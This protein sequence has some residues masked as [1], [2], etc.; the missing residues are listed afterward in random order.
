MIPLLS[1]Y[2]QS[3]EVLF[4]EYFLPSFEKYLSKSFR[5][6]V[7]TGHQD[8]PSSTYYRKGWFETVVK[9]IDFVNSFLQTSNDELLVFADVD[10]VF[11]DNFKDSLLEELGNNDMAF[12]RASFSN[13]CTGFYA[14]KIND[15]N[16]RFFDDLL[17]SYNL[18]KGDQHNINKMLS[19]GNYNSTLLSDKFH[20][21]NKLWHNTRVVWK[22]GD[23]IPFPNFPISLY[24][25]NYTI[26]VENK[27]VLLKGFQDW[28]L[29]LCRT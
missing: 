8:C 7:E 21:F 11:F 28:Q 22:L 26:G 19:R 4:D 25:A 16:K 23:N 24:H 14:I 3:H 5:L 18:N 2:T 27:L 17:K 15:E 29:R 9:K 13:A 12:Q 20:N 6:I 1:Y 10:I